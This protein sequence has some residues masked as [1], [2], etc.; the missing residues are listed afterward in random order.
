MIMKKVVIYA[1]DRT[2]LGKEVLSLF[3]DVSQ[4]L[5]IPVAGGLPFVTCGRSRY[6]G[7]AE[8]KALAAEL[9]GDR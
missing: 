7:L 8:I 1:D 9:H 3:A 4:V 5:A 6:D 2:D